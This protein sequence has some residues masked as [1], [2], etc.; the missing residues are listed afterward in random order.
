MKSRI[1]ALL[2]IVLCGCAAADLSLKNG[3]K[4]ETVKSVSVMNFSTPKW[5]N[6][7]KVGKLAADTVSKELSKMGFSVVEKGG[8]AVVTG[9]VGPALQGGRLVVP[10]QV[11]TKRKTGEK[12]QHM[13]VL[14]VNVA[15]QM[16]RSDTG[17]I[18]WVG[19][20]DYD[21]TSTEASIRRAVG[22]ILKRL[23]KELSL[24]S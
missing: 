10:R 19:R 17:E 20:A 7:E 13:E 8:D 16:A 14:D 5:T 1:S 3:F 2:F 11:Y 4:K 21:G 23:R 18:L 12:P 6:G 22:L 15:V 24:K 9:S